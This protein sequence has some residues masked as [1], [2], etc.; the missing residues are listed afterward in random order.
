MSARTVFMSIEDHER[1]LRRL[2]FWFAFIAG[3]VLIGSGSSVMSALKLF[4][5]IP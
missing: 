4:K 1:R 3:A 5:V 2:E